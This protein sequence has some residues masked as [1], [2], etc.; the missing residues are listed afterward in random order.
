V[1]V[2]QFT[3]KTNKYNLSNNFIIYPNPSSG[4]FNIEI[5][6][7]LVGS[8]ATIYNLLGQKI[9]EFSLTSRI[10]NQSLNK[11]IYLFEIEK[12]GSKT[13]KKLIMN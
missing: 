1:D 3:L 6:E 4:I 12:D 13:T 8:K 10:T 9:K 11:G 7:N 5:D 2:S